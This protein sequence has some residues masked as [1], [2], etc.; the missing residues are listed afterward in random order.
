[1]KLSSL[2]RVSAALALALGAQSML[3]APVQAAPAVMS[4]A[5]PTAT[6]QFRVFLPLRNQTEL[7]GLIAELHDPKS[8][9][10]QKWLEPADFLKRFGP[11][12]SDLETLKRS[13]TSDRKS[14]V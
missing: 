6:V 10:Y 9:N 5:A 3:N 2:T 1:M 14:V 4:A 7:D 13:M 12:E 11:S 8:A